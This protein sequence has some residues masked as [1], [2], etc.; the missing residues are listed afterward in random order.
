MQQGRRDNR[1]CRH[2][3]V[4][5]ASLLCLVMTGCVSSPY[6]FGTARQ[7]RTSAELAAVTETQIERGRS[8]RVIDGVGW[9]VGIPSKVL[10]WNRRIDNH[11]ISPETDAAIADYLTKN[12]LDTV[13]VRLNQYA[14]RD[15]WRR[16]VANK[17]VSWGWRYSLGTLSWLSETIV[18]GR[19]VGG[20]HYNPFTNTINVYSDVPAIAIH[21]AGHSKDFARRRYKGTYAALYLLPV[22]PLW[23]EA[24]ATNDALSYLRTEGDFP[25]EQEAYRVL[26]PAYGTYAGNAISTV[27][28][29]AGTPLYLAGV[30]SGHILGRIRAS[31]IG[32]ER[33]RKIEPVG[34]EADATTEVT[35][36]QLEPS[37]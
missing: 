17:S 27:V 32:K 7:Y 30:V 11:H 34:Y 12:E 29:A 33:P 28:P 16:L 13:K 15:E 5:T 1:R 36:T 2:A 4:L 31:R 18:P 19:L 21:E 6:R 22:V 37:R 9:V 10:L 14:P 3:R 23:H 20:D 25:D 35:E 8:R 24:I 26:Y